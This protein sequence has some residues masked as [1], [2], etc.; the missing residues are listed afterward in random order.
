MLF[1]IFNYVINLSFNDYDF[2]YTNLDTI[3][4]WSYPMKTPANITILLSAYCHSNVIIVEVFKPKHFLVTTLTHG[5]QKISTT[6]PN[7]STSLA[8]LVNKCKY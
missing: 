1:S 8:S 2:V 3:F 5:D 7:S 4:I 6:L